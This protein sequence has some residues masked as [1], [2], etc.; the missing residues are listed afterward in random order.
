MS[1]GSRLK[2]LRKQ[3]GY[4]QQFVAD[5]LGIGRSNLGH[6]ENDRVQLEPDYAKIL[7]KLYHTT[8]EF[9]YTG[10]GEEYVDPTIRTLNRAARD[11][12]PEQRKKAIRI[13]EATFEDLFDD[14]N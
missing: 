2:K 14:E 11:M 5:A 7:A 9:I 8:I 1:V 4:T 10:E 3:K 6:I 12:T 13:L